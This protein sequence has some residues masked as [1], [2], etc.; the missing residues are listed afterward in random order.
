V[1]NIVSLMRRV[2]AINCTVVDCRTC[3]SQVQQLSIDRKLYRRQS[4]FVPTPPAF[5]TPV[6]EVCR[7][8]AMTFGTEKLEWFGYQTVKRRYDY[9][10]SSQNSRLS[11]L[12]A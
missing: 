3:C 12:S 1:I 11:I 4:R 2:C 5:D 8:V 7:N 6:R 9:E 10:V